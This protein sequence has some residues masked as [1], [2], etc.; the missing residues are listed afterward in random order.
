MQRARQSDVIYDVVKALHGAHLSMTSR[1]PSLQAVRCSCWMADWRR[2]WFQMAL[3]RSLYVHYARSTSNRRTGTSAAVRQALTTLTLI[4]IAQKSSNTSE[5][6]GAN[7]KNILH[8]RRLSFQG[9]FGKGWL[10][11]NSQ[12]Y[13]MSPQKN[14]NMQ[15]IKVLYFYYSLLRHL[16]TNK[17]TNESSGVWAYDEAANRAR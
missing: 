17:S 12:C 10:T 3:P 5:L 14:R 16:L 9:K 7:W 11:I 2:H 6:N 13:K 15:H 8:G 4:R 1:L